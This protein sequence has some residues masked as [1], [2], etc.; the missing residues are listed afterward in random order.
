MKKIILIILAALSFSSCEKDDICDSSTATTPRLIIDFYDNSTTT[1]TLKKVSHLAIAAPGYTTS[2]S[3]DA[4]SRIQVPLDPT[5]SPNVHAVTWAFVQNG[6]DTDITNDNTD[7]LTFNYTSNSV[8]VS[9]AC[10]YKSIFNLDNTTPFALSD[11][12]AA[13]GMWI[14]N[15]TVVKYNIETE[16][17]VH[18]KVYF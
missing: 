16:N 3:F 15:V 5:P 2:N 9:R 8:Y 7:M 6:S 4:V 12:S 11:S 17:E 10:G 1:P 18:L 13:D 14:Q